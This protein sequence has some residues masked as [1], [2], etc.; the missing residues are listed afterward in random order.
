MRSTWPPR[1]ACTSSRRSTEPV[2]RVPSATPGLPDSDLRATSRSRRST[3]RAGGT[4]RGS[5]GEMWR[6]TAC[7]RE[8]DAHGL[9]PRRT[10]QTAQG[11]SDRRT[12]Q[13][14]SLASYG[15]GCR[16][17][18]EFATVFRA[19]LYGQPPTSSRVMSGR[20]PRTAGSVSPPFAN[21]REGVLY[22]IAGDVVLTMLTTRLRCDHWIWGVRVDGTPVIGRPG[23]RNRMPRRPRWLRHRG[24]SGTR[25]LIN[26]RPHTA[27]GVTRRCP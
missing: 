9:T 3:S 10:T 27:D 16:A 7:P 24:P 6:K 1:T 22:Q 23:A 2:A 21:P 5:I 18:T 11:A 8:P 12:G 25:P 26:H 17:T 20:A 19:G 14:N 15:L 4:S 13:S